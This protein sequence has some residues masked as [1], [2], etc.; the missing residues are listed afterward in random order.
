MSFEIQDQNICLH[1]SRYGICKFGPA[2]KY[3]HPVQPTSTISG[4]ENQPPYINSA[5]TAEGAGMNRR[6]RSETTIQQLV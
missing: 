2:C 4:V 1:Y 3:D 5:A 6:S